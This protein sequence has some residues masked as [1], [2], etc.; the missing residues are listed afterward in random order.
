LALYA[1][2]GFLPYRQGSL[3]VQEIPVVKLRRSAG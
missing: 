1:E 3:G 2:L